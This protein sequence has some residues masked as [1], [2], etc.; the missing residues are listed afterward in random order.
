MKKYNTSEVYLLKVEKKIF[1]IYMEKFI[2][3]KLQDEE[4]EE[5][6]LEEEL[7]EGDEEE[8]EE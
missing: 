6:D 8:Y 7:D 1:S 5:S 2:D 4:E 3:W